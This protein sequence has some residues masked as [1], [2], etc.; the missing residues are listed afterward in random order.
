MPEYTGATNVKYA[1]QRSN[2]GLACQT[3]NNPVLK[4]V[5]NNLKFYS[6]L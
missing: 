1:Q 5:Q 2:S 3:S 6:V 4:A